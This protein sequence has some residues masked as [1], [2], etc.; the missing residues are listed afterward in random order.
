MPRKTTAMAKKTLAKAKEENEKIKSKGKKVTE[1]WKEIMDWKL[2]N[3][4]QKWFFSL[5]EKEQSFLE[6]TY[7]IVVQI[8][9]ELSREDFLNR[10]SRTDKFN[11][12]AKSVIKRAVWKW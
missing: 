2:K 1:K 11:T 3:S 5:E 7:L 4:T 10:L 8:C 6:T 9:P 12:W